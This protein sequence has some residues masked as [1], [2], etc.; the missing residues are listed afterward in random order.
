MGSDVLEGLA[1]EVK[2]ANLQPAGY[3]FRA[4]S[5]SD[6]IDPRESLWVVSWFVSDVT[7]DA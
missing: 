4:W 2:M 6:G 5:K 1:D 7:G 3:T